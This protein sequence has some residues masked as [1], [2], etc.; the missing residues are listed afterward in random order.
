MEKHLLPTVIK[1]FAKKYIR[2]KK[3]YLGVLTICESSY[4]MSWYTQVL[5][6]SLASRNYYNLHNAQPPSRLETLSFSV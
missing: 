1:M 3:K 6:Y 2:D 5:H 4:D